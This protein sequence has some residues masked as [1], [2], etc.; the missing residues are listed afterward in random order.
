[1]DAKEASER[2]RLYLRAGIKVLVTIGF[3]FLLVPF[4]K[5]LP[6]PQEK[7]PPGSILIAA[8]ELTPGT[9]RRVDLPG[10]SV[11]VTRV[12]E[13]VH[14]Q[15]LA[16]APALWNP[17]APEL[18]DVPYLVVS[19]LDAERTPVEF[20]AASAHWPGG[21]TSAGGGAWDVAGRAMKP[22]LQNPGGDPLPRAN[23]A[24]MPFQRRSNGVLL[25]PLPDAP[26]EQMP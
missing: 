14:S 4:L 13:S 21:F 5:S 7:L 24:P 17:G 22:G 3:A 15:L 10:Q 9:A 26:P 20:R 19:G 6:W 18:L 2:K 12:N 16:L 11:W 1:M 8:S 25:V 23:L